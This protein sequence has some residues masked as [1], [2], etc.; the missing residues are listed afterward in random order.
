LKNFSIRY[1]GVLLLDRIARRKPL[2]QSVFFADLVKRSAQNLFSPQ[3]VDG[4]AKKQTKQ[5][6]LGANK[7]FTA[8]ENKN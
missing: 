7:T 1:A 6:N 8:T 3:H 4:K 5:T 2:H